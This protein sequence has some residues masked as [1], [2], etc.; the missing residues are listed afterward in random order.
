MTKILMVCLGNICRSPLAQGILESKLPQSSFFIDSAGTGGYHIGSPPDN[1]SVRVAKLHG[2]DISHQQARKFSIED[3]ERFDIIFAMDQYNKRDIQHL[4]K[5]QEHSNK[6]KIILNES[7]NA[8]LNDVPDPYYGTMSDF[9][10]V[11]QLL[12][13]AC[14]SIALKLTNNM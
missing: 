11:Y 9:E 5:T 12:D 13:T 2:I 1:R 6:V 3:F 10:D 4:A 8:D 7:P 14:E